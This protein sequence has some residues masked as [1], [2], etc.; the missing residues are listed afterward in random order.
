MQKQDLLE[1]QDARIEAL[2]MRITYQEDWLEKLD[3]RIIEQEK[4]IETLKRVNQLLS[5]RL[6][7]QR[8]SM[9]QAQEWRAEDE[10]PPHY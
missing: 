2:E 1:Q 5:E 8:D 4:E 10:R 9:N 6:R 7:E 3:T